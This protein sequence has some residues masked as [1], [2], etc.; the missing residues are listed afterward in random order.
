MRKHFYEEDGYR[1]CAEKSIVG[2]LGRMQVCICEL[3][4]GH[5]G[6][7]ERIPTIGLAGVREFGLPYYRNFVSK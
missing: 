6:P 7:C 1:Q 3:V 2:E 4:A 5:D